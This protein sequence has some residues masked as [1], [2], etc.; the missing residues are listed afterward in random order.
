MNYG[1]EGIMRLGAW[2]WNGVWWKASGTEATKSRYGWSGHR[3]WEFLIAP[4]K[5]AEKQFIAQKMRENDPRAFAVNTIWGWRGKAAAKQ[6]ESTG[7]NDHSALF[8]LDK[9]DQPPF[10]Y[11]RISQSDSFH[12][13]LDEQAVLAMWMVEWCLEQVAAGRLGMNYL[14]IVLYT[15]AGDP[16]YRSMVLWPDPLTGKPGDGKDSLASWRSFLQATGYKNIE[17]RWQQWGS[18]A[19]ARAQEDLDSQIAFYEKSLKV[20]NWASMK[21]PFNILGRKVDEFNVARSNLRGQLAIADD[22]DRQGLLT[23]EEK[24]EFARIK[25]ELQSMESRARV[26]LTPLGMWSDGNMQGLDGLA[27][28]GVGGTIIA[29]IGMIT[30]MVLS[31][32][33]FIAYCDHIDVKGRALDA[34]KAAKDKQQAIL[35]ARFRQIMAMPDG[36]A[37]IDALNNLKNEQADLDEAYLKQIE[38][39]ET[40]FAKRSPLARLFDDMQT[41]M[42][43]GIGGLI[44]VNLL[45]K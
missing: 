31:L 29:I 13:P 40:R 37:K 33:G 45:K 26:V 38:D 32:I 27:Q 30:L 39:I 35:D 12:L 11:L 19:Y 22:L 23:V 42:L 7:G 18:R 36:Q 8:N 3:W 9:A 14:D 34:V 1:G 10:Q 17:D 4:P 15:I 44:A 16:N 25:T 21:E 41:T 20:L 28:L 24:Q 6:I 5:D 43:I 2:L